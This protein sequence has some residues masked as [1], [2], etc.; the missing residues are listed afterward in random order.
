MIQ[1]K[2]EKEDDKEER[3]NKIVDNNSYCKKEVNEIIKKIAY[4][5]NNNIHYDN[6]SKVYTL[7]YGKNR[8]DIIDYLN[9]IKKFIN[10]I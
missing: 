6:K 9:T 5:V 1:A 3:L 7:K 8:S 4:I 2:Q 10:D